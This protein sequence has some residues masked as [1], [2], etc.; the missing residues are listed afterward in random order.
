MRV[1]ANL[2][3]T[4]SQFQLRLSNAFTFARYIENAD[5]GCEVYS[6]GCNADV[7]D[8]DLCGDIGNGLN[9]FPL[10]DFTVRVGK[11][12]LSPN[13]CDIVVSLEFLE[14]VEASAE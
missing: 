13:Q 8:G 7:S 9:A 4:F 3:M 12:L 14:F 6:F 1:D 10:V 11:V 2:Q 5:G